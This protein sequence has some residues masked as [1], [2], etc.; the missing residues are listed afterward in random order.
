MF[1]SVQ[2]VSRLG[3][4]WKFIRTLVQQGAGVPEHKQTRRGTKT[5]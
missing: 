3:E 2:L 4:T 1:G 5:K